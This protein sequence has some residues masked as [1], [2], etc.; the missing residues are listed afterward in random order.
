LEIWAKSL[1]L[2]LWGEKHIQLF[3]QF[4][5][6]APIIDGKKTWFSEF[7]VKIFPTKAIQKYHLEFQ[8][9][10]NLSVENLALTILE[11]LKISPSQG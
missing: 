7:L 1:S 2:W 6:S 4:S 10:G 3:I 5:G 9:K 8:Q 11:I